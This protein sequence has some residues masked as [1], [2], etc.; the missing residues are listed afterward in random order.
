MSA[1]V[2]LLLLTTT[3]SLRPGLQP[4][5]LI[6][7]RV[8]IPTLAKSWSS[9]QAFRAAREELFAQGLYP[10]VDY[11]IEAREGSRLTLRPEYPLIKKLEREWPVTVEEDLAPRWMDPTA[12]NLL[13][14]AFAV[15]LAVS[16]VLLG[17][18]LSSVL[19][20][21]VVNSTSMQPTIEPG[22]VILVEKVSPRLGVAPR[23]DE[24]V[25][26]EPPPALGEIVS[27][28]E[29]AVAAAARE[30]RDAAGGVRLP[31]PPQLSSRLFVKRVV[32]LPGE[33][34]AV[35][36]SGSVSVNGAE[37][38][39]DGLGPALSRLLRPALPAALDADELFVLGDNAA[40]SV[41]S[42]CWGALP[43][44]NLAGRP[45][46]RVFPPARAGVVK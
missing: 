2:P 13:T 20:L 32:A 28:R 38:A 12:Y 21:S 22:D 42:R 33:E 9:Q 15:G 25:F 39:R 17:V 24:L 1:A 19:T 30:E 27:K 5:E 18:V 37:L 4:A 23:R 29:A 41:D 3:S 11:K 45:L 31:P 34:V 6:V 35:S 26:F 16:A 8:V 43:E 36:P 14:A 44:R 10:G 40:A 7:G 46:V